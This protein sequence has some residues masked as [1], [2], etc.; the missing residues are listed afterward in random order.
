M[1]LA[2]TGENIR[3]CNGLPYGIGVFRKA[4]LCL[5]YTKSG[6]LRHRIVFLSFINSFWPESCQREYAYPFRS[7]PHQTRH[8]MWR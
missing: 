3:K 6:V 4:F 5:E 7:Y 1:I 2:Y 8:R